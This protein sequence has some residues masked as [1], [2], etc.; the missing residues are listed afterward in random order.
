MLMSR[1]SAKVFPMIISL[2]GLLATLFS[3]AMILEPLPRLLRSSAA[4]CLLRRSFLLAIFLT[5]STKKGAFPADQAGTRPLARV[6]PFRLA[7]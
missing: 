4:S 1:T 3:T 2:S 6:A 5:S 7:Y